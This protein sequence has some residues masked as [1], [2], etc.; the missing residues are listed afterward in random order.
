MWTKSAH[1]PPSE[2]SRRTFLKGSAAVAG[3]LA[4]ATY[5]DFGLR[6]AF[7]ATAQDA[8]MPNAFISSARAYER[9]VTSGKAGV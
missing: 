3:G 1:F 7:A 8:P 2:T 5:V 6:H 9:S 4:I